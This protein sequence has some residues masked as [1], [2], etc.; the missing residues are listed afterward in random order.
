MQEPDPPRA[1]SFLLGMLIMAA[2]GL[3]FA[4]ALTLVSVAD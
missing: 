4:A 3:A 1:S 2:I